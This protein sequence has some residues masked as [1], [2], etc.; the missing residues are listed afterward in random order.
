MLHLR[1]SRDTWNNLSEERVKD[2]DGGGA[3][4]EE[5]KKIN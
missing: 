1:G 5:G 2:R 4:E 3:K